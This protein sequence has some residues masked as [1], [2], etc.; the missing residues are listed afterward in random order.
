[1]AAE[2]RYARKDEDDGVRILVASL[3]DSEG[4]A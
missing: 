3:A 1:M 4:R 2:K